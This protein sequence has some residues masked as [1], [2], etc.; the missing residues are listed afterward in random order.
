M[1]VKVVLL[2]LKMNTYYEQVYGDLG[3][4]D[5]IAPDTKVFSTNL[6]SLDAVELCMAFEE[7]FGFETPDEDAEKLDSNPETTFADIVNYLSN[8]IAEEEYVKLK[9]LVKCNGNSF[10][11]EFVE[12]IND[13]ESNNVSRYLKGDELGSDS[14]QHSDHIV[15][16]I[17]GFSH[18]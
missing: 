15:G 6:D 13:K 17:N 8:R 3:H 11:K 9:G 5:E 7:E 4:T 12:G 1:I 14:L 18:K 2:R 16:Y 10:I